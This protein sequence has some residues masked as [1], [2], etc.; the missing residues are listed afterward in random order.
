MTITAEVLDDLWDFADPEGSEKRLRRAAESREDDVE[1]EELLTQVARALGLQRRFADAEA[2]LD[3]LTA[4]AAEVRA[5]RDLERGRIRN[6]AG[7]ASSA[8]EL[9]LAAAKTSAAAGL[10]FLQ[11]DAL[12]M[13]AIVDPGHA[14]R[15]TGAALAL[16]DGVDDPRTLRWR[17]SLHNNLGWTLLDRGEPGLALHSFQDSRDAALRWGT[18]QQVQWAEDA[19][20]EARAALNSHRNDA[21]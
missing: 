9:F 4:D 16:L 1:R 18:P 13:L 5:R 7:D 8:E 6:T 21:R 3:S 17:V 15:W 10:V 14:E 12:H 2:L 20:A 11:V 19:I